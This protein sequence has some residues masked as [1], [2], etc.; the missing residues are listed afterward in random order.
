MRPRIQ[1][2]PRT[3]DED[4]ARVHDAVRA[5]VKVEGVL[6][7]GLAPRLQQTLRRPHLPQRRKVIY[8]MLRSEGRE[9]ELSV[10]HVPHKKTRI[11][12]AAPEGV[13]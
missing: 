11:Q 3:A 5:D 6:T 4:V 7:R 13:F 8:V 1:T 10:E 12:T 2:L 9:A